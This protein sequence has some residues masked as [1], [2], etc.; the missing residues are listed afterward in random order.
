MS[1]NLAKAVATTLRY[2]EQ[3]SFAMTPHEVHQFLIG[4]PHKTRL[5]PAGEYTR[6]GDYLVP[7]GREDLVKIRRTREIYTQKKIARAVILSNWLR[8]FPGVR[9]VGITGSVAAGNAKRS[10]D[11][12]LLIVSAR[13]RIWMTRMIVLAVM[14]LVGIKRPDRISSHYDNKFCF[15]IWLE[16]SRG[17]LK[18]R[19]EDLY[20]AHEICLMKPLL[21]GAVYYRFLKINDWT[22]RYLPNFSADYGSQLIQDSRLW[23]G[24][25]HVAQYILE[26]LVLGALGWALEPLAKAL[27]KGRIE[28]K[29]RRHYHSGVSV[30][31]QQMMFHPES[32]RSKILA[33]FEKSGS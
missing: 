33:N 8:V 19:N 23:Q 1:P 6:V 26:V 31:D 14:S 27:S 15:N 2:A 21:G 10:D 30:S 28:S 25:G 13:G 12:D 22:K 3:F 20:T 9:M 4:H 24:F 18:I 5:I 17:G 11:I 16:E 29:H 32:P 7:R